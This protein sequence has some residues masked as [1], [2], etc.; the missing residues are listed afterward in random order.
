MVY[1]LI[2]IPMTLLLLTAVVERLLIPLG[3]AL[4][5]LNHKLGHLYSPLTIRILHLALV[6]FLGLSS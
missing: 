4:R 1:A 3:V 2:G 6:P 5:F